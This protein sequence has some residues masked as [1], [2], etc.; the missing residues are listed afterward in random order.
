LR[1]IGAP[2][3]VEALAALG[4]LVDRHD[5]LAVAGVVLGRSD[6]ISVG[7]ARRAPV[8]DLPERAVRALGHATR[9]AAWRREPLGTAPE[10]SNVDAS[11][12]RAAV[13]EALAGGGGW[14]D[15]GR[16]AQ[17]LAAYGIPLVP[18]ATAASA[19]GAVAAADRLGYPV[20]VK[21]ADPALVH[22]SDIGAIRLNLPDADA[23]RRAYQEMA[24]AL[25]EAAAAV[26]L[27]PMASG[28][29]ELA[30]GIVHDPLFGSL[31]T[32]G[33]GGVHTDLLADRAVR[34]VP[35]TDLDAAR[36]WRSLRCAPLLTGYRGAPPV[37]TTAIENLLARLGR[38]AQ[39]LPEVA[40]LDLNP[41]LADI[42]GVILVDAKLRLA[43]VGPEPDP[44]L[45]A[46]RRP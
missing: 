27:Q 33:L 39:D 20:A 36:M 11:A 8:F 32:T 31:V 19:D 45:R 40:E 18:S 2:V 15:A 42:N 23:V 30:A 9:Y 10:L 22:R 28:Q 13:A 17:I 29:V 46:L 24:D 26:L 3:L 21:A 34:L 41:V 6:L 14:Q 7:S 43:P 38:L 16:V 1:R 44:N 37:D 5:T 12:A 25:D 4:P 35:L